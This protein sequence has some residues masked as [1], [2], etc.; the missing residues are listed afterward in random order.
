MRQIRARPPFFSIDPPWR[1]ENMTWPGLLAR[2][3]GLYC[4]A[5]CIELPKFFEVNTILDPDSKIFANF[6]SKIKGQGILCF[7]ALN[8]GSTTMTSWDR[9]SV[10]IC[11]FS[12][13]ETV[14]SFFNGQFGQY[15]MLCGFEST[16]DTI[17][18]FLAKRVYIRRDIRAF[19]FYSSTSMI[20]VKLACRYL[21]LSS[22]SSSF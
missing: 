2:R 5:K 10:H 11:V 8:F 14:D 12:P 20:T 6:F 17:F 15:E 18:L 3:A 16:L 4:P 13:K 19:F 1:M 9:S 21:W 22:V 7:I